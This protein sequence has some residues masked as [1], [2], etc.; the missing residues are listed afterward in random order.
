MAPARYR[1]RADATTTIR[2]SAGRHARAGRPARAAEAAVAPAADRNGGRRPRTAERGCAGTSPNRVAPPSEFF[3]RLDD[4]DSGVELLQKRKRSTQIK[5]GL[6]TRWV[7]LRD[8][9][10]RSH[11]EHHMAPIHRQGP[12]WPYCRDQRVRRH[13]SNS[14]PRSSE[15][16]CQAACQIP[17]KIERRQT[18]QPQRAER[19]CCS[20]RASPWSSSA[21]INALTTARHPQEPGSPW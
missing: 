20:P 2:L 5:P 15:G 16:S 12:M 14:A 18:R 6:L 13:H 17:E 9:P 11:C 4:T 19:R 10:L 3:P 7:V 8:H 21:P 1:L